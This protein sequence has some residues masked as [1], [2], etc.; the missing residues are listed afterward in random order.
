[1]AD[2]EKLLELAEAIAPG[3]IE[4]IWREAWDLGYST[5]RT[6][7]LSPAAFWCDPDEA[8][9][10]SPIAAALRA[11]AAEQEGR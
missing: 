6:D 5:G 2:R 3:A 4:A 10:G 1:M 7:A 9:E 8:W 11:R